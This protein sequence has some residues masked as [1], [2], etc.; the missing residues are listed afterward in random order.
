MSKQTT[1]DEGVEKGSVGA[2]TFIAIS[3]CPHQRTYLHR[4]SDGS[5]VLFDE[6]SL[7]KKLDELLGKGQGKEA[8]YFASLTGLARM[9]PHKEVVIYFDGRVG[10]RD[11]PVDSEEGLGTGDLGRG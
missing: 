6:D 10:L 8:D 1:R 3:Y 11:L 5:V 7:V 2:V 4:P 9:H